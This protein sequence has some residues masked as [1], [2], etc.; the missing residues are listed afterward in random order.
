MFGLNAADKY[1]RITQ[2]IAFGC[3]SRP[4]YAC[5]FLIMH[6]SSVVW[7]IDCYLR[8]YIPSNV[9]HCFHSMLP[10]WQPSEAIL[11]RSCPG[12]TIRCWWTHYLVA[13]GRRHQ[14]HLL[15]SHKLTTTCLSPTHDPSFRLTC[16]GN[17]T[18]L[19]L[20]C[21][22]KKM[23]LVNDPESLVFSWFAT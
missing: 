19:V 11:A 5:H 22:S 1:C 20:S 17:S 23:L 15:Y 16:P 12:S 10:L 9:M 2:N 6:T 14:R 4:F 13:T 3:N 8:K 7:K 18:C 21:L